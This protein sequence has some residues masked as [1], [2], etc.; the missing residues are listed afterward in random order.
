MEKVNLAVEVE[1]RFIIDDKYGIRIEFWGDEVD[2][3]R[4][5][6]IQTQRSIE[7]IQEVEINPLHEYLLEN[8]LEEVCNKILNNITEY[9]ENQKIMLKKI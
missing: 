5:F 9:T 7:M 1:F 6:D 4:K 2:S 8:S 3:I